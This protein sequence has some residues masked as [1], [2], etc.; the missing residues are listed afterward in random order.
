MSQKKCKLVL[1]T[2]QVV[3]S[4]EIAKSVNTIEFGVPGNQ[5]TQ[6]QVKRILVDHNTRIERGTLTVE[7][8]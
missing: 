3:N 6:E 7:F 5:L 2:N 8:V 4:F 1:K